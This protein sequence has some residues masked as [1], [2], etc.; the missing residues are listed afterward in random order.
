[1]SIAGEDPRLLPPGS[2]GRGAE[3]MS[4]FGKCG[5]F[6]HSKFFATL[7]SEENENSPEN[8]TS[9]MRESCMYGSAWRAPSNGRPCRDRRQFITLLGG[10]AAAGPPMCGN[11]ERGLTASP[12]ASGRS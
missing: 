8:P 5:R 7:A 9:R 3:F 10:A 2:G 4:A 6:C 12:I 11:C 1:M